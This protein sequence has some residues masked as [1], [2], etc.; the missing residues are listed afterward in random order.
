MVEIRDVRPLGQI[1]HKLPNEKVEKSED[2]PTSDQHH[3]DKES[4][5][6]DDGPHVDEYA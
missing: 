1:W 4:D 2:K 5:K 6:D 3:P